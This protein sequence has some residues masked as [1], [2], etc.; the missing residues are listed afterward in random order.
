MTSRGPRP[1]YVLGLL[2]CLAPA[3]LAQSE[4]YVRYSGP[5]MFTYD[6]LAVMSHNQ[7]LAPELDLKIETIT[8]TPFI[9]NEAFYRGVEPHKPIAHHL[10]PS[11]RVVFW[12]IERGMRLDDIKLLFTDRETFIHKVAEER[13]RKRHSADEIPGGRARA[14][15]RC[16]TRLRAL[17]CAN[18]H[19]ADGGTSSRS[20]KS[21]G[22]CREAIIAKS[23]RSSARLST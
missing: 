5:E 13:Y 7:P 19:V 10:G 16:R 18:P 15:G 9:S 3:V 20:T 2:L 12:N 23:S 21:T 6:E 22:A 8:T 1:A 11:L 14:R 17:A 4:D